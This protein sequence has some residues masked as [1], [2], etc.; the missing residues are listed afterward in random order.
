MMLGVFSDMGQVTVE[1]KGSG[2][3]FGMGG[4]DDEPLDGVYRRVLQQYLLAGNFRFSFLSIGH[5]GSP[6]LCMYTT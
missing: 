5:H 1:E 6:Y 2:H 3:S 4:R